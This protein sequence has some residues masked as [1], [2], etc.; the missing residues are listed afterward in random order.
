MLFARIITVP[1]FLLAGCAGPGTGFALSPL[2]WPFSVAQDP[3]RYVESSRNNGGA[4]GAFS[5]D[6]QLSGDPEIMP[7]QVFDDGHGMWLQFAPEG[8]WPAVFEVVNGAWRPLP[9]RRESPYMLLDGVYPHLELRGGHLRGTVQRATSP[10]RGVPPAVVMPVDGEVQQAIQIQPDEGGAR[11]AGAPHA[12]PP[13]AALAL[14]PAIARAE[15]D[16]AI[17]G[18][19]SLPG[20]GQPAAVAIETSYEISE[21]LMASPAYLG[22]PIPRY[23]VSPA[24]QTIR[25]ALERWAKESGWTFAAEH[26][27][28]DVD[29][30][31]VGVAAFDTDFK[32]AV[33]EL[34]AATEMGDRPL[35][36]C[37][38]S[39][40][41]LRV[42]PY[43]QACDRS[44]GT[45][46]VS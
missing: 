41:V 31:L 30:P 9:Y 42:V 36:P 7:V 37:F 33:R 39:N 14:T 19:G 24:D 26:W 8:A 13:A 43:A 21:P 32:A 25:Q 23:S 17:P 38:Y 15:S 34:L 5:F 22:A 2:P 6:W 12:T 4:H 27:A 16:I 28:V 40:Q 10:Q 46:T 11:H 29:I 44:A 20:K 35:Q 45:R 1:L 18:T 3:P